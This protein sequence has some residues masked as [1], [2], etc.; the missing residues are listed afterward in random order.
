MIRRLILDTNRYKD[1][2]LDV[3]ARNAS[4]GPSI[5]GWHFDAWG[6]AR[7]LVWED[8]LEKRYVTV[9]SQVRDC[10]QRS[11]R[12][13]PWL[14]DS[15]VTCALLCHAQALGARTFDT[16]C[17][18][19]PVGNACVAVRADA[20]PGQATLLGFARGERGAALRRLFFSRLDAGRV[21]GD[22]EG[23]VLAACPCGEDLRHMFRA[24]VNFQLCDHE[25][26]SA[27]CCSVGADAS[28]SSKMASKPT[29]IGKLREKLG[30]R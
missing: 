4:S 26:L 21:D 28:G 19:E 7:V 14:S 20:V 25:Q 18:F 2:R 30:L 16:P 8:T 15:P 3:R 10:A 29:L 24:D 5:R 6:P 22:D 1:L 13:P 27:V 12:A 9:C 23:M 17:A 11:P